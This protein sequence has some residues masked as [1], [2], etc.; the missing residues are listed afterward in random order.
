MKSYFKNTIQK[1]EEQEKQH[2]MERSMSRRSKR[3]TNNFGA[4]MIASD[5]KLKTVDLRRY[6]IEPSQNLSKFEAIY[7][8]DI[9]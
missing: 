5:H 9:R 4:N 7:I 2:N 6:K 3:G 8:P 1:K